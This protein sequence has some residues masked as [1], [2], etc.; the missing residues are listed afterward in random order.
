MKVIAALLCLTALA[1]LAQAD[2][3]DAVQQLARFQ[4]LQT[5]AFQ[6]NFNSAPTLEATTDALFLSSLYGLK[7]KINSFKAEEY[8]QSLRTKEN[9]YSSSAG[10]VA[11]LEATFNAVVSYVH[12]GEEVPQSSAVVDFV[13]SLVDASNMFSNNAGGRGNI[14]ST[15]QAIATLRALDSIESLPSSVSTSLINTLS[16]ANNGKYFDFTNVPAIKSNF[17][18][19]YIWETLNEDFLKEKKTLILFYLNKALLVV[20]SLMLNKP[21]SVMK[22]L[23][24]LLPHSVSLEIILPFLQLPELTLLLWLDIAKMFLLIFL[25]LHLLTKLLLIHQSSPITLNL[26]SNT[27]ELTLVVTSFY[28]EPNYDQKL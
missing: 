17:Y 25:R 24:S 2:F 7:S 9:G 1:F 15:Y 14:K 8:L 21:L 27:V 22:V 6:T 4:D 12:L 16:A 19:V 3:N 11:T 26:L 20:S 10:G 23:L 28:K 5:G 18:G 13:L